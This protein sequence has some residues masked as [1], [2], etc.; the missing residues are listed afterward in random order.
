[1]DQHGQ[2]KEGINAIGNIRLSFEP[3]RV[4]MRRKPIRKARSFR[5]II[6]ILFM[7]IEHCIDEQSLFKVGIGKLSTLYLILNNIKRF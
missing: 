7:K 5:Y 4:Q 2:T 1:M 6:H 3:V